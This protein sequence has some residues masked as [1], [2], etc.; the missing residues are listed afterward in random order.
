PR[1]KAMSKPTRTFD[2]EP[3]D[4]P[5]DLGEPDHERLLPDNVVSMFAW[6]RQHVCG[7]PPVREAFPS[8]YPGLPFAERVQLALAE[9]RLLLAQAGEAL[10]EVE[11][12]GAANIGF[13]LSGEEP[14]V[15]IDADY[16]GDGWDAVPFRRMC[17]EADE[18]QR[19]KPLDPRVVR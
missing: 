10:V 1:C 6:V 5:H 3:V 11:V 8:E 17:R 9:A 14:E 7:L 15:D 12:C 18:R 4:Q 19:K 13:S 2:G 16:Q